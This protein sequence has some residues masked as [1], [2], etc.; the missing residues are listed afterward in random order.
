MPASP[1]GDTAT[2]DRAVSGFDSVHVSGTCRLEIEQTGEESLTIEAAEHVTVLYACESG[3]RAW[4]GLK[5]M[6]C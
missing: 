1:G 6:P 4:G 2:A 3:S 5:S